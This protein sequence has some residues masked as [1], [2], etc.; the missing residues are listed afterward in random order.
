MVMHKES[1]GDNQC[2]RLHSTNNSV[3]IRT[4]FCC[5]TCATVIWLYSMHSMAG[6][7]L[8]YSFKWYTVMSSTAIITKKNLVM[9][10]SLN[11][12]MESPLLL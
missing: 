6:M 8:E 5:V 4:A 2:F 12:R 11:L 10:F 9:A 3:A 1:H 7:N